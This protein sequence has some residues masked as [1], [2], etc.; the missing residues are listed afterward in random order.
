MRQRKR[1]QPDT[2][3]KGRCIDC[4]KAWLMRDTA[5][6]NPVIARCGVDG[7]R[8]VARVHHCTKGMFERAEGEPVIHPMEY[9]I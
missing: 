6:M 7:E 2:P 9:V 5:A 8:N 3:A 1:K 4:A